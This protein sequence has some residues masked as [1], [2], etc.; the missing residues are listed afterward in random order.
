MD[1]GTGSD[2]ALNH[3]DLFRLV[4]RA[5]EK[6]MFEPPEGLPTYSMQKAARILATFDSARFVLENLP[7]AEDLVTNK[8]V[9]QSAAPH[10]PDD[11]LLL[12]FGVA[13]GNSIR[14]LA[15]L[16]PGRRIFGFD[17]FQGLPVD[18]TSVQRRGRFSS[19]GRPPSDLP[20]TVEL[21]IGLFAD[22]LPGFCADNPGPI[23]LL[24]IDSDVYESARDVF[25]HLG[26]RLAAGSV[27]VFDEYLNYPGWQ[28]HE[29]KAFTE[30]VEESGLTFAYLGFASSAHA[31][32]VQVIDNPSASRS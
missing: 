28:H 4:V 8:A 1:E 6:S 12:E 30:F 31:V 17:S 13:N 27:S 5:V 32:A 21:V 26:S 29:H 24:H 11:G 3:D 16:F 9:R 20:E 15:G 2:N 18:W 14:Q 7:R 19:D 22:V 23:A 10:A 25:A